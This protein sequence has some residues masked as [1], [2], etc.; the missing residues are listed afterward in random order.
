MADQPSFS[1]AVSLAFEYVKSIS[2]HK[3]TLN[4]AAERYVGW[5]PHYSFSTFNLDE[6][7]IISDTYIVRYGF[8]HVKITSAGVAEHYNMF[9][10]KWA[11][12]AYKLY[13]LETIE[14]YEVTKNL[15]Y[16]YDMKNKLLQTNYNVSRGDFPIDFKRDIIK[17]NIPQPYGWAIKPYGRVVEYLGEPTIHNRNTKN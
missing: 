16:K 3:F 1:D 17:F 15:E 6:G 10:S 14:T 7:R 9:V 12:K 5:M 8:D 13:T 4:E 2:R 11:Y